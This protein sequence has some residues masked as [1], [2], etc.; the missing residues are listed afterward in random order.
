MNLYKSQHIRTAHALMIQS[1][2]W[3]HE[4]I[5]TED[6]EVSW[7]IAPLTVEISNPLENMINPTSSFQRSRCDEYAKQ[8]IYGIT[9]GKSGFSYTYHERMFLENQYDD[10][11]SRLKSSPGTRRAVIYTWLPQIDN[12]SY[13]VPCLQFLQLIVRNNKL[14]G[15]CY[16]RSEDV[17]SAA[18]PN[19]Y[20]I[21]RLIE[22]IAK[23]LGVEVGTYT[24]IVGVP[25]L[26][27]VRDA[28]DLK[29]WM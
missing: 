24:H 17:L 21:V 6:N 27:P 10:I 20:G 4:I 11:L 1:I 8:I 12:N 15:V 3:K 25:H 7:E 2:I 29:R 19:M 14:N 28:E 13:E 22:H 5:T 18:G 26:Y 23:E 9:P 16:F